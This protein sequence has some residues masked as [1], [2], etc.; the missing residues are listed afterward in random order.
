MNDPFLYLFL[1]ILTGIATIPFGISLIKRRKDIFEPICWASAFFLLLFVVRAVFDLTLGSAFISPPFDERTAHAFTLAVLYLIPSLICFLIG[2]YSNLGYDIARA[3]PSLP[4]NWRNERVTILLPLLISVGLT[5]QFLLIQ[6]LGGLS[7]YLDDKQHTLT[8][9]GQ[10]Y[11]A[12]GVS[13]IPLAFGVALTRC[14]VDK[15]GWIVTYLVLLPLVLAL[16]LISGSKAAFL[17]PFLAMLVSVHYLRRR[18]NLGVIILFALLAIL[19]FPLFN[20]YRQVGTIDR[21]VETIDQ[22]PNS[23][24]GNDLPPEEVGEL[25]VRSALSRFLGIDSLTYIIRDTPDIMDFQYGHTVLGAVLA[26]VPRQVWADKPVGFAQL[27]GETYLGHIFYGT[28]TAAAP[29]L[30]GEAYLNWHIGGMVVL[31]LLCGV[32]V[33]CSYAYLIEQQF[34]Q[35]AVFLY[36]CIFLHLFTFWERSIDGIVVATLTLLSQAVVV[37]LLVGGRSLPKESF[38]HDALQLRQASNGPSGNK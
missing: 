5:S 15:N 9:P 28:G 8:E 10:G 33:R 37:I 4:L 7:N 35:P 11:W 13:L 25:L 6:Y 34:G 2:Y 19:V 22:L 3:F 21:M 38:L 23:F 20:L 30:L 26:W 1:A 16:G 18:V 36:S 12:A 31:A 14:L 17:G 32:L 29:T 27:F 24:Y